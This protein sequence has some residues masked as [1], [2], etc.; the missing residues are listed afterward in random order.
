MVMI[1]PLLLCYVPALV[2]FFWYT[3]F[4]RDKDYKNACRDLLIKG[5]LSCLGVVLFS[6]V[7][8]VLWAMTGLGK[9]HP[10]LDKAFHAFVL[11]AVSEELVKYLTTKGYIK[12][13]NLKVSWIDLMVFTAIVGI[14]FHLIESVVYL[15][16]SSAGQMIVR[17]FTAMHMT[18]G[19]I[20]G[21]YF[22][23][24]ITKNK[25][26]Y[27]VLALLIPIIVHGFYDFT[28]AE[29][30]TAWCEY[31][32]VG[33]ILSLLID[34]IYLFVLIVF[35]IKSRKNNINTYPLYGTDSGSA[36]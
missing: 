1:V 18:H 21:Y 24:A 15:F 30:V 14:G 27:K 22:G 16:E 26:F 29:E 2:F 4:K 3:T 9:T 36:E 35:I 31:L 11:A 28:L 6:F 7:A 33:P 32:V 34:F 19:L 25:P 23:K 17:G 13:H 10:I 20:I 8:N 5:V 12:K